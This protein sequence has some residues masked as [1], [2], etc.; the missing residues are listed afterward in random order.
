M[1]KQAIGKM[2]AQI[3]LAYVPANQ[4]RKRRFNIDKRPLNTDG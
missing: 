2:G 4:E 1:K 3:V